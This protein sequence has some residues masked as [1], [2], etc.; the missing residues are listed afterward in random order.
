M[1][2]L[3]YR[4]TFLIGF[5]FFASSLAWSLYNSFVPVL[6]EERYLQ[7]TALIG[8]IMTIDNMFGVVF[9]P[10][11]GQFSDRTRTRFGKRMPYILV[12]IPL[13]AVA[14]FFIPRTT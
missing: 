8:F 2:A 6:L 1:Q 3:N 10:L 12:G 7:S 4:K 11:V 9:Q 14:F 13:C 5:G